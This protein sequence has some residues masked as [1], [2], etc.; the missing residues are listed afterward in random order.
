MPSWQAVATVATWQTGYRGTLWDARSVSHHL[1]FR[2]WCNIQHFKTQF[3]AIVCHDGIF[4]LPAFMLQTDETAGLE[5]FHGPPYIW[6]NLKNLDKYN[7]ARPDL[8]KNWKTPMLI[9]HSDKDF[10]C[11]VTEGIAAY[12]TC[13]TLGVESRFLNFPDENHFV[14][15][16]ENSLVWHR[17][18][19]GWINKYSGVGKGQEEEAEAEATGR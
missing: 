3:K 7:P 17:E 14:L 8:L 10:R 5:D 4:H 15:K 2:L 9:I 12:N 16:E 6:N 1:R 11:P 19:F 18:V 13:Q